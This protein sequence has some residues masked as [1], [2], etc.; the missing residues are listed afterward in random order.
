M[1]PAS[2][3]SGALV[4]TD[5]AMVE[6]LVAPKT[7]RFFLA[8]LAREVSANEVA[9]ELEVSV[10]RLLYWIRRAEACGLLRVSRTERRAGRPVRYYRSVADVIFLPADATDETDLVQ[11][12]RLW[13]DPW[14]ALFVESVV[15]ALRRVKLTGLRFSRSA[16]GRIDIKYASGPQENADLTPADMPA[17]WGGWYTDLW[18]DPQ[19]AKAFQLELRDLQQKYLAKR[20]RA[21][22]IMRLA[23]AP[24]A[25]TAL[26]SS[27]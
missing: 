6:V 25:P 24:C 13:S 1:K 15:R 4:V 21:R 12:L 8:F 5:P 7:A 11:V 22:Y 23:L 18:L 17:I 26:G 2:F 9:K 27:E 10:S 16:G 20:G 19:D 3:N 14:Q